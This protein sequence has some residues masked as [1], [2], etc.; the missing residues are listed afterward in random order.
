MLDIFEKSKRGGLT[1][2]GGK[3]YVKANTQHIAG[4]DPKSKSTNLL[5][6]DA[7]NLYGLGNGSSITLPR[8]QILELNNLRNHL[9]HSRRRINGVDCRS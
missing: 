2:V 6:L 3:R 4:Y 9:K 8:Y 7:N 5:S 1:F